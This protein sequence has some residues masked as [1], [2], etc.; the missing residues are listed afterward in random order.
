[1]ISEFADNLH[2][3][4][5]DLFQE[6]RLENP[7]GFFVKQKGKGNYLLHHVGCAH[8]GNPF[9]GKEDTIQ[10]RG[11]SQSL[12]TSRKICSSD[13]NELLVW[14]AEGN[15]AHEICHHCVDTSDP[16]HL[17]PSDSAKQRIDGWIVSLNEWVENHQGE[18][19]NTTVKT[20][21]DEVADDVQHFYNDVTR[22]LQDNRSSRQTRLATA[23]KIPDRVP[24]TSTLFRRNPDVVAEVLLRAKGKCE[25]CLQPAPFARASDGT[26]YLEVHHRVMLAAGGEDTVVNAIALCPNCHRAAHYA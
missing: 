15:F 26:P 14:L 5:H 24:T 8:I 12:T 7:E 3:D 18:L 1:M 6:W 16:S 25:G 19:E 10:S 4:A 9:W 17:K 22:S 2:A 23:P 20:T 13:P 21:P 11:R